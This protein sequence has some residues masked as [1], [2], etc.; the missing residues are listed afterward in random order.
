MNVSDYVNRI[1][2]NVFYN[3]LS[4]W[5]NGRQRSLS[6]NDANKI[7]ELI[8]K[9][10]VYLTSKISAEE[11]NLS[12]V[13]LLVKIKKKIPE[14]LDSS[15]V[16]TINYLIETISR[17]ALP[18][19]CWEMI[20]QNLDANSLIALAL[21]NKA[22]N[23]FSKKGRDD[24]ALV[25]TITSKGGKIFNNR[26]VRLGREHTLTAELVNKIKRSLPQ[27][28][29]LSA[30]ENYCTKEGV[31]AAL[32]LGNVEVFGVRTFDGWSAE[33]WI[34]AE[35]LTELKSESWLSTH[36]SD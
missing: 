17:P 20:S 19:E 32:E 21:S 11:E 28:K 22:L 13:D 10:R 16:K 31:K 36:S 26:D 25:N 6:Y 33:A 8:D 24:L 5:A 3:E 18:P 1:N 23:A 30:H 12:R 15:L 14:Q 29:K 2:S 7:Q 34:R 27:L 4:Q 35:N 9:N